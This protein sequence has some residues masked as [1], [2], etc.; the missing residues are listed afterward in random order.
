MYL[1]FANKVTRNKGPVTS[2]A[3]A[4]L[5]KENLNLN[6]LARIVQEEVASVHTYPRNLYPNDPCVG[7]QK[8][9]DA[10]VRVAHKDP[11]LP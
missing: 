2:L 8:V 5:K 10:I 4:F 6:D 1:R 9:L 3:E 11:G 7:L